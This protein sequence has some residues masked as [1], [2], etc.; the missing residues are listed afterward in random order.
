MYQNSIRAKNITKIHLLKNYSQRF[1][2]IL[3][4]FY[5]PDYKQLFKLRVAFPDV[6][7]MAL[8]ATATPRVRTDIL[9]QLR[10]KNPKWFLSS[11]NRVNLQYEVSQHQLSMTNMVIWS[12]LMYA[13]DIY[14]C[15][16]MIV[17]KSISLLTHQG[18]GRIGGHYFHSGCPYVRHTTKTRYN[19]NIVSYEN[20]TSATTDTMTMTTDWLW[21][22]GSLWSHPT[23]LIFNLIIFTGSSKE[24][25]EYHERDHWL[26]PTSFHQAIR[27]R[28]LLLAQRMRHGRQ[29]FELRRLASYRLPCWSSG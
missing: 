24:R 8:T 22:D 25:K 6:P 21:L 10:M 12:I 4:Y 17:L 3:S 5:R 18:H 13:L 11:F 2:L 28:L 16:V 26:D 1:V 19:A 29:R 14:F 23:W 27:Y 7:F 15:S 9:H 20:K